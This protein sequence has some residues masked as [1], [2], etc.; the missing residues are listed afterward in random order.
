MG[1]VICIISGPGNEALFLLLI[2]L[3]MLGVITGHWTDKTKKTF[4]FVD[5]NNWPS[6]GVFYLLIYL[7]SFNLGRNK[8]K[9]KT[10]PPPTNQYCTR[11]KAKCAFFHNWNGRGWLDF[12]FKWT[13]IVVN[14][15]HLFIQFLYI[16]L[17][18][19][20]IILSQ[21]QLYKWSRFFIWIKVGTSI[22]NQI[23]T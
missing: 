5:L 4:R 15:S 21:F 13:K 6:I 19:L 14:L 7:S 3:I 17:F 16:S 1:Q 2:I 23:K 22:K 9:S 12:S 20:I 8:I 18:I 10:T 11:D